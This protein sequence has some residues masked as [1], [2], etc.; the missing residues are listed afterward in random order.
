MSSTPTPFGSAAAFPPS[1]EPKSDAVNND[2]GLGS[3]VA[4]QSRQR[5]INRDGTFNVRRQGLRYF[6]SMTAYHAFI[7][8]SWPKFQVT[9]ISAYLATNVVFAIA[10]YLCGPDALRGSEAHTNL[11]RFWEA[12]FFSVQTLATIGYGHVSPR[13]IPANI[14]VAVEAISGLLGFAIITG[15]L[16]ARF[17]RPVAKIL[18]SDRALVAPYQQGSAFMFRI[19]NKLSSQITNVEAVVSFSRWVNENG[20]RVR[21]FYELKLERKKVMFFPLHWVIVHPIDE[22]SPLNGLAQQDLVESDAEFVVMIT[23]IDELFAQSVQSRMSYKHEEIVWGAK[24]RDM[25]RS[26]ENDLISIDLAE[27]HSF[28]KV[29][30]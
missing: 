14:L 8:M 21:R 6:E 27:I 18:Y 12:F 19:A 5:Y 26:A 4:E 17:S 11:E 1:H 7:L 23:G 25:F 24:F 29:P 28:D 30:L 13:G 16:F 15:M 2:L 9:V 22:T 10:F 20:R 3:R